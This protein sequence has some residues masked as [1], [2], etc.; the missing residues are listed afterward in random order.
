MNRYYKHILMLLSMLLVEQARAQEVF[1]LEKCIDYALTNSINSKNADIDKQIADAKVKETIGM[2]LP[3]VNGTASVIQNIKLRRFFTT[4]NPNGGFFDFSAVPGI[5]PGDV[6]SAQNFFQLKANGDAGLSISQLL[7]NG[8]YLVG[9]QAS[10]AYK[11]LSVKRAEQTQEQIV[12]SVTKAYYAVIINRERIGLFDTNIARVDSLLRNTKA[13]NQNGFVEAID[14]DRIQVA[15]NNLTTERE[16]FESFNELSMALLKFQMNYPLDQPMEVAGNIEHW[17]VPSVDDYDNGVDYKNRPDYKVMEVNYKLQ[18]LNVKNRYAEGMPTLAAIANLGFATQSADFAGL[19]KTKS[20]VI[21]NGSVGPDK[22]YGYSLIGATLNVPI[23][24]GMSRTYR[25]KQEK[26]NLTKIENGMMAMKNGIDLE[27]KQATITFQNGV[28]TLATQKANMELAS[29]VARVTKI[30][31]EQGVG[32]NFEVIDAENA[33]KQAQVN[34][35]NAL[36][37]VMVAKTDLDKA[38][39]KLFNPTSQPK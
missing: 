5:Q 17:E 6:V 36:F 28:K 25:V 27:M 13:L 11:E 21:D 15:L 38:H 2:G 3:Q 8:S 4:Y 35:Y 32:S 33:L 9:L 12:L 10:N 31:Y 20:A 1:T 16:K 29:N 30:K 14:V 22:W 39:G 26:L 18:Q 7:F 24:S 37:D 23:F 19:Y 34:Y